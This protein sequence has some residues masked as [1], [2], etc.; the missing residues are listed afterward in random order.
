M[1]FKIN[2]SE[3]GKTYKTEIQSESIMEKKVGDK[4]KGEEIMPELSGYE[5][6]I[7]GASDIAGFPVKKDVEGMGL[8]RVLLTKGFGMKDNYDGI[9]KRK[10]VRANTIDASIIQL[11][12]NVL[13]Q[14]SK[15]LDE[16]FPEQVKAREDKKKVRE[17]KIKAAKNPAPKTEAAPEAQ[18]AA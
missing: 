12:L 15:K 13:K 18:T 4:I 10:S 16:I 9:R 1:A 2:I 7:T 17:D 5:L 8:R 11:N 3:K 6:E 14:G